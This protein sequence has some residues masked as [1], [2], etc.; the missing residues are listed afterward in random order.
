MWGGGDQPENIHSVGEGHAECFIILAVGTL[1]SP[2]GVFNGNGKSCGVNI[3]IN[4]GSEYLQDMSAQSSSVTFQ[5]DIGAVEAQ[6][7]ENDSSC[8]YALLCSLA[9]LHLKQLLTRY[10]LFYF[11]LSNGSALNEGSD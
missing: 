7:C 8:S 10:F 4:L 3:L 2:Y 5:D 9:H 1:F 11:I 6:S